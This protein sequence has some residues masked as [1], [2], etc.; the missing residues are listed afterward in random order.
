VTVAGSAVSR[1]L[2]ATPVAALDD[3]TRAG[4]GEA[5]RLARDLTPDEI[6]AVVG[7]SGLRGHGG[8]GFPV[9]RKWQSVAA[10]ESAPGTASVVVNAA[11]G[12]PGSFK[13]R[14]ILRADPYRVIE[15]ALL[16]ARAVGAG[17]VVLG[18][19]ASMGPDV[20]RVQRAIDEVAA[21][22]WC[23]GVSVRVV[24]GP[25]E[26]LL[27]EETAL[28]EVIDGRHPF[29]RLAP[30][31]RRGIHEVTEPGRGVHPESASA[32]ELELASPTHE[33][34]AP[35]T[36]A[37]NLETFANLPA[38]LTN[39]AAWFRELGTD[40]APGTIVCTV[41]GATERAAV[42]EFPYG[43]PL[44]AILEELGSSL[45]DPVL[46]VLSGVANPFLPAA[47]LDTPATYQALRDAG[48]GL[49][50]A[51]FIVFD[52][53]IDPVAIAAGVATFLAVE[54][55][56]QCTPCKIDGLALAALLR[57]DADSNIDERG[58]DEIQRL[59]G[60]V[61]DSA[62]CNLATQQQVVIGSLLEQ[63]PDAFAA[64]VHHREEPVQAYPIAAI[65][66]IVDG[67]VLLEPGQATKQPDWTHDPVDSGQFPAQRLDDPRMH[68]SE[69]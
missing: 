16:A 63:F 4:G 60:T 9:A 14:T 19:R 7:E 36:L 23:D 34:D 11:E 13:D 33:T 56:G 59:L 43:T 12:E 55:C 39:G 61:A 52:D 22:G 62:R 68:E 49:G 35:P 24:A 53:T 5:L 2:P 15:G 18:M 42:G 32:A 45:P 50:A 28:L 54:S 20:E 40:D 48:S 26:Y 21:A 47:R 6:I 44:R 29:P 17:D 30:P 46:G 1:V 37:G 25:D 41:S 3:A 51:G 69:G 10:N 38:I 65:A 66:D 31:Y 8:A 57:R 58:L 27:G 67:R 64:H